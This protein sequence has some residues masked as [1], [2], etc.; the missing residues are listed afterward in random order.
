MTLL[1]GV[2]LELLGE[3][4]VSCIGSGSSVDNDEVLKELVKGLFGIRL[5]VCMNS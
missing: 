3:S 4:D 1:I 5:Q 2:G